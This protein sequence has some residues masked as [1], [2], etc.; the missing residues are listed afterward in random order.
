[1][2]NASKVENFH[3][4]TP[5]QELLLK[6]AL[7]G[8]KDALDAWAR[9]R[10]QVDWEGHLDQGSFRLLPL[11]YT[12]LQKHGVDD[13]FMGKLKGI[14]RSAWSKNQ[15]LFHEAAGDIDALQKGGIR[16]MLVRGAALSLL[17]YKNSGGRPMADVDVLVPSA[18]ARPALE[19]LGEKGW[20]PSRPVTE[21]DL[22]FGHAVVLKSASDREF[23]L[24]WRPFQSCGDVQEKDFWDHA[25]PVKLA[26][27]ESL[28][29]GPAELLFQA[30]ISG[31]DWR[32]VP[33][34]C[35]IADA[36]TL[37]DAGVSP[38]DWRLIVRRAQKH[39]L[40]LRLRKGL[41]YLHCRFHAAIPPSVLQSAADLSGSY[42]ERMEYRFMIRNKQA[43]SAAPFL[44]LG[45][46]LCRF[47]R[48][49]PGR[50]GL[51]L[52]QFTRSLQWKLN[53]RSGGDLFR[54]GLSRAA[55]LVSSGLFR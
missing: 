13:P 18:Q 9:W 52:R 42:L 24:H 48:F 15:T 37:I 27:V 3:L 41:Q 4:I 20:M 17:Y 39:R 22:L 53:A 19:L 5:E 32:P 11:L 46:H 54:I 44:A 45:C 26:G 12:N 2:D 21:S 6:A 10:A 40:S 51:P 30:I 16:T 25:V 23:H 38:E 29:P 14:Y 33:S 50:A 47:R 43:E 8:G 1:M 34:T 7:Q 36:L 31:M 28:A 55:A 49:R 35:W